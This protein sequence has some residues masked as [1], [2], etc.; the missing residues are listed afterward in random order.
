[1]LMM[2]FFMQQGKRTMLTCA[3]TYGCC[4]KE[5]KSYVTATTQDAFYTMQPDTRNSTTQALS[6]IFSYNPSPL[7]VAIFSLVHPC[8]P[9]LVFC[10]TF[11]YMRVTILSTLVPCILWSAVVC[12]RMCC[13][14]SLHRVRGWG[15]VYNDEHYHWNRI[16]G[17]NG[18]GCSARWVSLFQ[19]K[20]PQGSPLSKTKS[21]QRAS[22]LY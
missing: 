21:V 15:A 9:K 7:I 17:W 13:L 6:S 20:D 1:M 12:V 16:G 5:G 22:M 4:V 2:L 3:L 19:V 18:L 14:W 8:P 11:D 10:A